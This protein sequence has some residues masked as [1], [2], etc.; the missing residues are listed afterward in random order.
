MVPLGF[1]IKKRHGLFKT[2]LDNFSIQGYVETQIHF[3]KQKNRG[4]V[5]Y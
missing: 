3:M 1:N 4:L 5:M 2:I